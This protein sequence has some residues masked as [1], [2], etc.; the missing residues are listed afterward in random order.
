MFTERVKS[1]VYTVASNSVRLYLRPNS[2][3]LPNLV[4]MRFLG[5]IPQDIIRSIRGTADDILLLHGLLQQVTILVAGPQISALLLGTFLRGIP[6]RCDLV[7]IIPHPGL[8][9]LRLDH[10]V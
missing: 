4:Q 2:N 5:E 1:N 10:L 8:G 3:G 9:L 6:F 7:E